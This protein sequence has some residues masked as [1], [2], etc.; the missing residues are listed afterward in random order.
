MDGCVGR[1]EETK[2]LEAI[3]AKTPVACAICGRRHLGKTALLRAFCSDKSHVY[4]S[5]TSGLK[6][7]NLKQ[8]SSA[9][10]KFS[11]KSIH[12]DDIIDFFPRIKEVCGR[13]QV[14]VVIDRYSDLVSNF[15]E[16]NSY[17]R[18]FM[19]RDIPGTKIMLI[20]CDNDSSIFGRFYYTLDLKPMSYLECKGFHPNYTP[21]EHLTVYSIVGGTPAYQELFQGKPEDVIRD[22]FFDH[23]SVFSLE[24][25]CLVTAETVIS[26]ACLRILSA[27]AAGSESI[28]DIASAAD[29]STSFCT[30]MVED[31]EH[32]G[33]LLKEVSSGVS[34]RAVYSISSNI[35]RFFFEIVYKYTPSLEF[36]TSEETYANAKGDIDAYVE[37]GFK[38]ICMEYVTQNYDYSFVGKLRRKDDS[39]DSYIDFVASVNINDVNR[40]LVASCR[41]FGTPYTMKDLDELRE[42]SKRVEGSNKYYVLFS[43]IGFTQELVKYA[44]SN[45]SLKLLTL[46]DVYRG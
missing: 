27:M 30:K 13:K 45:T 11:G 3:Y 40:I 19:N 23:M 4:I 44:S 46:D 35:L 22:Q 21:L 37:R 17:L 29:I 36:T 34:R 10:S 33:L 28:K 16:F 15:P 41:L 39:K 42:R 24:A 14:V 20:V 26:P 5:G 31:M 25:E 2:Y 9:L 1:L 18:T 12:I 6:S 32:K 8:I 38:T 7:D 43:G